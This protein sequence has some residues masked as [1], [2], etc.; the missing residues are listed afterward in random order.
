MLYRYGFNG[1]ENDNEV[2]GEGN[3]QDYGMR[4]YDPR[5]GKF[6]SVDP[7]TKSYPML[8]PYQFGSNSPIENIDLDG[9]EGWSINKPKEDAVASY[10]RSENQRSIAQ[11]ERV[12]LF[13]SLNKPASIS[14]PNDCILCK[15]ISNQQH[16]FDK[17]MSERAAL[18]PISYGGP[19]FGLG[20]GR[21]PII[22]SVASSLAPEIG[23]A[24]STFSTY[25]GIRN[26]DY[27]QAGF[28]FLLPGR[29][30]EKEDM[31]ISVSFFSFIDDSIFTYKF[32][33]LLTTC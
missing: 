10:E 29:I 13:E 28:C 20:L 25:G 31:H 23:F 9:M 14:R 3:E 16:A 21:D 2:K 33:L 24:V 5:I 22:Q 4:V 12:R 18:D 27:V 8:T 7:L 26:R 1:K 32:Y 19:G 17:E 6:L 30:N 15:E 11:K